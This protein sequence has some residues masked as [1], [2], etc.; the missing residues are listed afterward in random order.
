MYEAKRD[1]KGTPAALRDY[2]GDLA[3]LMWNGCR[4]MHRALLMFEKVKERALDRR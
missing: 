1:S 3:G 4:L 2:R